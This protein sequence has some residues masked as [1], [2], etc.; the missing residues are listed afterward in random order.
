MSS[1]SSAA[2]PSLSSSLILLAP[3]AERSADGFDYRVLLLKRHGKASSFNSA[4]VFPGGNMDPVDRQTDK[5]KRFLPASVES[6]DEAQLSLKLCAIRETFEE[7][8]ILLADNHAEAWHRLTEQERRE[9]RDKVHK[10]GPA[11]LDLFQLLNESGSDAR[12]S[13]SSLTY[14]ANWMCACS[15]LPVCKS[16]TSSRTPR[17]VK[18]RFDTHFYIAILP[19]AEQPKAGNGPAL[20]VVTEHVVSSDGKETVS[21]D[22]MTPK[23]AIDRTLVHTRARTAGTEPAQGA[24]ILFPPQF[25]LVAELTRYKSWRDLVDPNDKDARGLP[26]VKRRTVVPFEPE[27]DVVETD[28]GQER[29]A[30]V[31][32]G[33]PCHS[34]TRERFGNDVDPD[35]RHR[36]Y[37]VIP[38]AKAAEGSKWKAAP[39]PMTTVAGVQ[40]RG[41]SNKMDNEWA[42]MD[43]GETGATRQKL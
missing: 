1:S 36:T 31:L 41:L 40:R 35:A 38:E 21:A 39:P 9:W 24:L 19:P 17:V 25:Y 28:D 3:L 30:T 6:D 32:P 18:R 11:F 22:W 7:C 23:Q 29:T 15:P 5:W 37:V 8:G 13:V 12:P 27:F 14:R 42:D 33:D 2:V 34:E 10:N 20:P 4:H 26:K 16:L 43:V